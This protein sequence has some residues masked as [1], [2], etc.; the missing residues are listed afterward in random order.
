MENVTARLTFKYGVMF[1]KDEQVRLREA[2]FLLYQ[3]LKIWIK[4]NKSIII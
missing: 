2:T 1:R 4:V 3:N